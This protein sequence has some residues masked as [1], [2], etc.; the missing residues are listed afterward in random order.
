MV[1]S[2]PGHLISTT[3]CLGGELGKSL[4]AGENYMDFLLWNQQL[5]GKDFYLEMQPGLSE[6]Q[7]KVES[8]DCKIKASIRNKKLLL[9]VM[10]TI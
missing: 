4:L 10:S 5:F 8:R 3:A 1:K 6:E 2:N 9:P 7:I